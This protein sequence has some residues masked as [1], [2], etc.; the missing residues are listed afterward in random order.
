[1]LGNKKT[2]CTKLITTKIWKGQWQLYFVALKRAAL[3]LLNL[4]IS[5]LDYWN[6]KI[7]NG[8][9]VVQTSR[10]CSAPYFVGHEKK[11]SSKA[12]QPKAG[13]IWSIFSSSTGKKLIVFAFWLGFHKGS[14]LSLP[15]IYR[16]FSIHRKRCFRFVNST[17]TCIRG[18]FFKT[19][20]P[21]LHLRITQFLVWSFS[22][23]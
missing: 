12:K 17:N 7:L 20:N 2:V 11:P 3:I 22:N 6:K 23:M 1:M 18:A 5:N 14:K 4:T 9:K 19:I 15:N 16:Q 8:L 10:K 13:H 21:C